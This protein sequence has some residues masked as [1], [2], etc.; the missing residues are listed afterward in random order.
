MDNRERRETRIG[1][2][3]HKLDSRNCK[4]LLREKKKKKE[5]DRGH[6]GTSL[7]VEALK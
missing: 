2:N 5:L 4:V 3:N 6:C 7:R 1:K